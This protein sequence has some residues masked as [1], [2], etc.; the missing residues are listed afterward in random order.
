MA[1]PGSEWAGTLVGQWGFG[2][3][4]ADLNAAT[5]PLFGGSGRV[6]FA[7]LG[8]ID[9]NTSGEM[10]VRLQ[11]IRQQLQTVDIGTYFEFSKVSLAGKAVTFILKSAP[12]L[13]H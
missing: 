9:A 5:S 2:D 12:V 4:A 6:G 3:T 13:I 10:K 11:R 7:N 1:V 8:F